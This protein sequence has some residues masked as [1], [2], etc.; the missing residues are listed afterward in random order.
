[1]SK[2]YPRVLKKENIVPV[3]AGNITEV[4]SM[5]PIEL[6]LEVEVFPE[7]EIDEKKLDK[8]RVKR[9]PVKVTDKDVDT[10]IADIK[11]RFTHFHDAG[12]HSE[13]GADTSV[14]TVESADRVTITAQGYESK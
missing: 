10:E 14:L 13:D 11:K 1:M 2:I 3:S 8:I 5:D 4:K 9:T 12:S 7:I 6:I